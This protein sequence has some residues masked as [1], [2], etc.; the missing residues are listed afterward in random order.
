MNKVRDAIME[1]EEMK[2]KIKTKEGELSQ[3]K[4][5][6]EEEVAVITGELDT[7]KTEQKVSVEGKKKAEEGIRRLQEI[8]ENCDENIRRLEQEKKTKESLIE[9]NL[10]ALTAA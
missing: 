3:L 2:S 4:S 6:S 10:S 8:V 5:T 1:N 9:R 7:I